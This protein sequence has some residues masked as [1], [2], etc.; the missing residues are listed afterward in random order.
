MSCL[1]D[2]LRAKSPS[3]REAVV[4]ELSDEE[5][6]ALLFDWR[7]WARPEQLEPEGTWLVWL[8]L[9]GR[10]WGKTRTG[11]ETVRGWVGHRGGFGRVALVGATAADA[12]D[13]MVE[14][15][16]G[17]L[18]CSPPWG[19]P[20]YEP[21]KRRVTW[22]NGAI[23][24][25]YSADEPDRLRGP[26][27]DAAWADELAAWR[28][29]DAW[30]QLMMGLRL[31]QSPRVVVTTTPRPVRLVRDLVRAKTTHV[32]R[33]STLDNLRNLAPSF[34]DAV[35]AKYEGTTLGR[36]EIYAELLD[37]A[38][39]ALWKRSLIDEHR[40]AQ[41]PEMRR[42]VVAIDPATTANAD[43]DETGIVVGGIA[44]NGH[45]YILADLSM[46]GSPDTWAR[47]AVGAYRVQKADRIVYEAN[48]G[49]DMVA[50]TL[51]TV[52]KDAPLRAV[53][54][55]RGKRTR[56]EPIAALYE[57]GR[58]HHV[59]SLGQLEDQLCNWMP[60][61]EDSPD[62]LDALV[63]CVTELVGS[64]TALVGLGNTGGESRWGA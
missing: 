63:W 64:T 5:A 30:D 8:I 14:G 39:G 20:I 15:E 47:R 13:V 52:D 43:S 25:C 58:V 38:P 37:E 36:Q 35:L 28:Y 31:G 17:I 41:A 50:H 54:A 7:T 57:Q 18:A 42:I 16:S 6:A 56:A 60:G 26:Q 46:R 49:G 22:P 44:D 21:S 40:V 48:Q 62:R 51:R 4:A 10:G 61:S 59:G 33:G 11:A 1:A 34:R 55:S 12:R 9:A 27:H 24:T 19:R 2:L 32:T 45:A 3:E 29:P 23:A 53:H